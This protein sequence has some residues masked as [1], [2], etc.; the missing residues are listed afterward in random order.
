[1][2]V[3][4]Y[5]PEGWDAG[6]VYLCRKL[7]DDE[8]MS[9]ERFADEIAR[10]IGLEIDASDGYIPNCCGDLR[11]EFME[12]EPRVIDERFQGATCIWSGES[13]YFKR[14]EH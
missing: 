7:S 10:S 6:T 8:T 13:F 9:E 3:I 2:W 5:A 12:H 11:V 1:M 14:E 4:G